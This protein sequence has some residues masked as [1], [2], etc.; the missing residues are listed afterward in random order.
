MLLNPE[1]SQ[2][3]EHME[4]GNQAWHDA[5]LGRITATGFNKL[6]GGKS[7]RDK[8]LYAK[9]A[10]IITGT[11]SDSDCN[12]KSFHID[13]GNLYEDLARK[14]YSTREFTEIKEVG[15]VLLGDY[16]SCSP[17]GLVVD[18]GLIEIKCPDTHI[19]IEKI[20]AIKDKKAE[21]ICSEHYYQ[22]QF[23][24]FVT[25]RDWCDYVLYNER[26]PNPLFKYRIYKNPTIEFKAIIGDAIRDMLRIVKDYESFTSEEV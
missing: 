8:Y 19:F 5:R 22:M 9:A 17:D 20:I 16:V 14:E 18:D 7:T 12:V 15:I 4:Q 25:N 6:M 3:I 11:K 23:N 13:R 10:E 21:G 1:E 24:M 26:Y 2:I